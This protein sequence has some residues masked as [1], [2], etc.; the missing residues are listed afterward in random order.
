MKISHNWL[1]EFL[2]IDLKIDQ[3]SEILT[4]IGLE[5]EGVNK[6]QNFQGGLEGLLIG[7]VL[8][9]IKHPNAD[10]L[11][12]T[13][14]DVGGTTSLQIVCG[15]PNVDID[16]TVIVATVGTTLY[17]LNGD[18]FKIKKSKIRG[19]LSQ[20]MICAEDEIGIG[21]SH[22]GIIV[23]NDKYKAGEQASKVYNYYEDHIF[24]IGLT[25]NRSRD[26][27]YGF[28]FWN[29]KDFTRLYNS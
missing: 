23:L 13:T 19:E 14:V 8:S 11:K 20:G 6:Y 16:Q 21:D 26:R 28:S 3:I 4:D 5:V 15:A 2:K 24:D 27:H 17:P 1:K 7:K 12:L 22:E 10:R 9:C 18:E 29:G 25:P